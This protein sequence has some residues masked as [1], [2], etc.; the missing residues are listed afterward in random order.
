MDNNIN[1][2][3]DR[4]EEDSMNV[5]IK[6]DVDSKDELISQWDDFNNMPCKKRR[7]SDDVS[8][9]L[10]GKT[11]EERYAD[12]MNNFI[13]NESRLEYSPDAIEDA[14][15]WMIDSNIFMIYPADNLQ[16]LFDKYITQDKDS[17]RRA[18]WKCIELFG[19]NNEELYNLLMDDDTSDILSVEDDEDNL[20]LA[21][22]LI[23][24]DS[25]VHVNESSAISNA[26]HN[27]NMKTL[28]NKINENIYN[29]KKDL[30]DNSIN[31]FFTPMEIEDLDGYYSDESTNKSKD[32][33]EEYTK[34]Y[35][36]YQNNFNI[37]K[38]KNEVRKT[39]HN[40]N[41]AENYNYDF[42]QANIYKQSLVNLG[43]NPEIEFTA[44]NLSRSKTRVENIMREQLNNIEIVDARSLYLNEA[45]GDL[46]QKPTKADDAK[47]QM[48][49]P[50]SIVLVKGNSI[51][52]SAIS[53]VTNS[54]FSHSAL[55]LDTN[56]NKL[57]SFNAEDINGTGGGFTLEAIKN[58]PKENRLAIFTFFVTN[59]QYE[60]INNNVQNL[61]YNI[62]ST[63]YSFLN[64]LTM[65]LKHIDL[66]RNDT[67]ICSQ[68]VDKMLKSINVD[69][70]DK[71]SSKV[72][73]NDFYKISIKNSKIYKIFDG[74]VKDFDPKRAAKSIDRLSKRSK[75]INESGLDLNNNLHAVLYENILS[76]YYNVGIT[77]AISLPIDFNKDGDLLLSKPS[78][79]LDL[80]QEY[81]N[82][83]KLLLQYEKANNLESMKY[84]LSRLFYMNYLLEKRIHSN[85][86]KKNKSD[87][88]K[89]RARILNDFNKYMK[90]IL[91]KDNSFNFD[92][93]Y[94]ETPF[95]HN[96][97]KVNK[98]IIKH[99]KDLIV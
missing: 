36:G 13:Q 19:M 73:P 37:N 93:Y 62:K 2:V 51:F 50:I 18:D 22:K 43:W 23:D 77:E 86:F 94:R 85:K 54:N 68:F 3:L 83:H 6:N 60:V 24:L 41:I 46:F 80:N 31:P 4:Y 48:L 97:V 1:D 20:S 12:Q 70:T 91:S 16:D 27:I 52:S 82:S 17:R 8:V 89:I 74:I 32:I 28:V 34:Y 29:T 15:Q 30:I 95:Y 38:W 98:S 44:E 40:L 78:L 76:D 61:L 53:K 88:I 69:I 92:E 21:S 64:I 7:D 35:Y 25:S 55:G 90:Y 5:I 63:S 96:T 67:L 42:E 79:L 11:N 26:L 49:H 99:L 45:K 47:Q 33:L 71:P 66:D 10:T 14:K 9:E 75:S 81:Y 65:P 56:F 72:V 39:L 57:Y 84:E 59:E 58:Y 87:Y